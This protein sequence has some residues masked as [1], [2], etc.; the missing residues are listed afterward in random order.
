MGRHRC[1][2]R[3]VVNERFRCL[4]FS[5]RMGNRL[6]DV[7]SIHVYSLLPLSF[8]VASPEQDVPVTYFGFNEFFPRSFFYMCS[9]T[10]VHA[11]LIFP[12]PKPVR[13]VNVLAH[14]SI[15]KYLCNANMML[16][17]SDGIS[18]INHY[19][20]S[21]SHSLTSISSPCLLCKLTLTKV[22]KKRYLL[23]SSVLS[24]IISCK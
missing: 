15:H 16:S 1:R 20:S 4:L 9:P 21:F 12:S 5:V 22:S 13:F 14:F 10:V 23:A 2:P 8:D 19:F 24:I 11:H 6:L 17:I 3:G 7:E 18:R